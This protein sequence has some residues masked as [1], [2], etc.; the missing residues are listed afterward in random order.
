MTR[1]F[2]VPVMCV[3][4]AGF[5]QD[6]QLFQLTKREVPFYILLFIH[7]TA[8]QCLLMA[9]SLKDLLLDCSCLGVG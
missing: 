3:A 8:A 6:K 4:V 9:L 7:H 5:I 1:A 2:H